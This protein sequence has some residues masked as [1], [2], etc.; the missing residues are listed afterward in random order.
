M[1]NAIIY[2]RVSTTKQSKDG[3]SLQ[4]QE[5]ECRAYCKRHWYQVLAT[6]Q[7]PF[8]GTTSDR[9]KILEAIEFVK[10]SELK[11]DYVITLKVNRISRWG[12]K[13]YNEIVDSFAEVWVTVKDTQWVIQESK[14]TLEIEWI[15]TS[16]YKW[17]KSNMNTITAN[18][19]AMM[20]EEDKNNGL[21]TMLWQAMRNNVRG[22]KIRNSDF[23]YKNVKARTGDWK[24]TIQVENPEESIYI[25]KMF[26]LKARGDMSD[27]E[28]TEEINRMWY[29]SRIR[30]KWNDEKTEIIG[31]IG[32]QA[33]HPEQL[34]RYIK[35]PIYAGI[36][37]EKW[38]PDKKPIQ[39]PYKGLIDIELWNKANRGKQKIVI[40]SGKNVTIEYF[41]G[42][43]QIEAPII[44]KPKN[45]NPEYM[46]GKMLLCPEC[47]WHMTAEKARSKN[48]NYYHYYQCRGKKWAKHKNY[49][50]NRDEANEQILKAFQ[51]AKFDTQIL[52]IY[53]KVTER[54]FEER[55]E[56][57]WVTT[58]YIEKSIKNLEQKEKFIIESVDKLT[59]YPE[60][61]EKKYE[62]L[63]EVKSQIQSRKSELK[64]QTQTFWLERFKK[65]SKKILE[66]PEIL[67]SAKENPEV[68]QLWFELL[69]GGKI[70]YEEI[71]SRTPMKEELLALESKKEFQL[72]WNS[73]INRKWWS[74]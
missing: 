6:F 10:N 8:T 73:S 55:S 47:G 45:Y 29:T 32:W 25:K 36:V 13:V 31:T 64:K 18:L 5:K 35:N 39:A 4:V 62:E 15:D 30:N 12:V 60:F 17:A 65:C 44:K 67:A 69:F 51:E 33:L 11:V 49:S 7:E 66:H 24:K 72:K 9:P 40:D 42:K 56:E 46:Y 1:K 58:K 63:K 2:C 52:E 38:T 34:Q 23:G 70:V 59:S 37:K 21:S 22:Y 48:G 16:E 43:V 53:D 19:S 28:I 3:E 71:K 27:K 61:L 26:E 14:S 74:F 68:I 57:Q 54:V 50:L 20:W 41:E